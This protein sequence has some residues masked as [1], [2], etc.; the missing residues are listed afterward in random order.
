MNAHR[1]V[2]IA[3]REQEMQQNPIRQ[4]IA[5]IIATQSLVTL[6]CS[7][8]RVRAADQASRVVARPFLLKG[9]PAYQFEYHTAG[10]V[11]HRNLLPEEALREIDRL[12]QEQ[13]HQA[14]IVTR[15]S[16][17][18][19]RINKRGEA[20]LRNKPTATRA[21]ALQHNRTKQYILAEGAPCDFLI[22]LGVMTETGKVIA[23]RYDKYRQI[24]RFLEMVADVVPHLE[25]SRPLRIVDFG[26]GKSY[27][28][29]A[30]YHYFRVVKGFEVDIVG[31]DLKP[32]VIAQCQAIAQD[33][34]YAHLN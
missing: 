9:A 29:F 31:L 18:E 30:L 17:I 23:A 1:R 21:I 14:R 15:E 13:F 6:T 28:T 34:G 7:G 19:V 22:R 24:N 5:E 26:C 3:K 20:I 4:R 11:T 25:A 32:E 2:V 16:E 8:P 33:L 12:L 10:K 27:L